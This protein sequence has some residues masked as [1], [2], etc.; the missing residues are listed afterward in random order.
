MCSFKKFYKLFVIAIQLGGMFCIFMFEFL[1]QGFGYKTIFSSN[2][3][4]NA[5]I[6]ENELLAII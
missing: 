6:V 5:G 4:K 1:D 3:D 2:C